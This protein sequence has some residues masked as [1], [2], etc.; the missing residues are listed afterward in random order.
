MGKGRVD[1]LDTLDNLCVAI[2]ENTFLLVLMLCATT[3]G[4]VLSL[5]AQAGVSGNLYLR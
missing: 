5:T 4:G 3:T 1:G 2:R